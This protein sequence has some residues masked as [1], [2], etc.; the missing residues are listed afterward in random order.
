MITTSAWRNQ[1]QASAGGI[2][3]LLD[4]KAE[5][6]LREIIKWTER[7]MSVHFNGNPLT[8][9]IIHYSPCEGSNEAEV[10]YKNLLDA[11]TT[12][13][14]HNVLLT[15]GDFNAHVGTNDTFK[16]T[17]HR[18][19]NKN[20]RLLIDYAEETN[21]MIANTFFRKRTGKLW[22]FMS[23]ST[24][25]K[26]QVD[27][28]LIRRKWKNSLHNCEAYNSFSSVGSDHRIL[29]AKLKLSLRK[30]STQAKKTQY[31]WSILK[32]K[33]ASTEYSKAVREKFNELQSE[34]TTATELYENFIEANNIISKKM[35][36]RIRANRKT[37]TTYDHRIQELREKV[38]IAYSK[39]TLSNTNE[40]Y[41]ELVK[42]KDNLRNMYM[43]IES[44]ALQK[45]T[46]QVELTNQESKHSKCWKLINEITGRKNTKKGIIKAKSKEDRVKIWYE[47]FKKLL[48]SDRKG[49]ENILV[50]TDLNL[51]LNE[52]HNIA[53]TAFTLEEYRKVTDNLKDGKAAGPDDISPE[54]LKYCK[55]DD[56]ILNFAN[57]I[58]FLQETPAQWTSSNIKPLPKSGDLSDV[59]NYRGISLS[60]IA[61]KIT[62]KMILNRI[63]PTVDKLLRNNQNG[64]RP[65]RGTIAH[66]LAIRRLIEG[67]KTKNIQSII[68]FVDF[69]K[70][71][72]SIDRAVLF[73]I[74]KIYGIPEI[75]IR[76]IK[77]LHSNS[78]AQVITPDGITETFLIQN[79]VLQGD[80]LAPFLF[81]IALD[82][83]MRLAIDGRESE[84]G[85][86]IARKK[87]R[88]HPAVNVTDFSYADDV[89][90]ISKN[91]EEAQIL[92]QRV[93]EEC[94]NIGL[95]INCQKTEA[96]YFGID[97]NQHIHTILNN[98]IKIVDNFK[99]LGSWM[100]SSEK[101]FNI[102][103]ALAWSAAN[104]MKKLW[105]SS[106]RDSL[107]VRIFRATIETI[108]TYGAE[109]WTTTKTMNKRIDGCY[110]RLLRMALNISWKDKINNIT[111][112]NGL[113]R[114]S[115][116]IKERRLK[117]AGHLMRHDNEMAHKLVLWEPTNGSARRGRKTITFVDNLREDIGLDDINEIKTMMLDRDVWRDK[118]KKSRA[119]ARHK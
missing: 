83:A 72:D 100:Q 87:S 28:I 4:S 16:Y 14:R 13:P 25:A 18:N 51:V 94:G 29:T 6:A 106:I 59:N 80:T 62:N 78:K 34:N 82:Y 31:D 17:Y 50:N 63:Q 75:L 48:G 43:N 90:L 81:I 22:T 26:T 74:L 61:S 46:E 91:I 20:G 1:N 35:I 39:H 65:G 111:L 38:E 68:T 45:A 2:G 114:I 107:K 84:I 73:K 97:N 8:T 10:H 41:E 54:I 52:T 86:E 44:N 105:K 19:S 47:H 96:M 60:S 9:V 115:E 104:K 103:K 79:G 64:F 24:G 95:K 40:S 11:T 36:P 101:D 27:Y 113:S 7:I 117:L 93:E 12:I 69:K 116:V 98:E 37:N 66:I 76:A 67:I 23:D 49:D 92:L 32:N 21:M 56:I 71:F 119:R 30:N 33:D 42:A 3:I 85:F 109:T 5:Q 102:R 53:I 55:F 99:Y 112:Y 70:A 89:A 58:L 57:N 118:A 110:T 77:S 108:Y 88:R 15:I